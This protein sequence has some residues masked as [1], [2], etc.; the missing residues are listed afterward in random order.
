VAADFTACGLCWW[1]RRG[2]HWECPDRR[3]FG[4][5]TAFGPALPG[6]HAEQVR[7]PHADVVL[8][9]LPDDVSD[10]AGVFVGDALATA[11][12]AV[13]RGELRAGDVIAVVGGGPIGQLCAQVALALGSGVVVLVE[14]VAPRRAIA[15]EAGVAAV[16]PED[17]RGT[18]RT[19]TDGRGA[20]LVVD[21][22]G[23]TAI[24]DS[25]LGLVRRRGTVCSVGVPGPAAW[26]ARLDRLLADEITVRFVV[27][28][29]IRDA[30]ALFGLLR[31]GQ[32]DPTPL[33]TSVV[34]LQEMPAG[35]SAAAARTGVKTLVRV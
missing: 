16:T 17:A 32:V 29:A 11:F 9:R 6:G 28:D 21:A 7:V 8:R 26:T 3:F 20:D 13:Q 35:L 33:V 4:T 18:V 1:C 23:G 15:A 19:L 2:D 24:L 5:G 10:D 27:G 30:D 25:C 22:V 12:A 14:P 31:G 34:P